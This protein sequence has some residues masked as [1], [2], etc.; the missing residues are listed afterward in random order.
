MG[1]A[2]GFTP[3]QVKEMSLWEYLWATDG[4]R[5]SQ[6]SG[7]DP[8]SAPSEEEFLEAVARMEDESQPSREVS[9]DEVLE[10]LGQSK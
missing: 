1:G 9:L 3:V 5:K 7:D 10:L 4:W 6:G 2:A 8:A